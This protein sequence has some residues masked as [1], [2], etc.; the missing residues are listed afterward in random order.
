MNIRHSDRAK[1]NPV[2]RPHRLMLA[3]ALAMA[4]VPAAGAAPAPVND[5]GTITPAHWPRATWPLADDP[6]M[7]RR[8]DALIA[9]MTLEE[10]VGQIVQGDIASIT[11]DDVRRYRL[12][13]ILAGG[14]SDPGGRY[15]A[16]PAEWLAL[17]DAFWEAS[18]DTRNGGKAIPIVWGIDAMHGQSNVVGATLFPHNIGLGAARNPELLREIARITAAETRVTGME[19][20]FAPTVAVPQD[21]R[22]GRT[23]E[24]YSEDPALVASYAGAFVEGLQGKAGAADFLDDHHVMTTVK[25]FLGDGGT[26]NGKDQGNT[27]VSE[28]ELRDIHAAGYLPA[29]NA[30]AQ[31][32]MASFNSFH[33]EKMHGHK[34]LLTDVLKGRMGFG[35]FVVGDWNGHGQIKGCSNTDCAKTYVAGL[36]MAMAPDSWKGM[37]ESTLAHVKDGSLPEARLDDAVRRI[38]RAKMRMGLF[39]KPKPSERALGGRFELLG[40]PAHRQVARQAVRE[41]L[42]LLKNQNQLLPLP[43]KQRVLVAGDAAN[44]MSR[45]AGGWTLSWQGDGTRREDFP[46]AET[47][48]EGLEAQVRSGGGQAELAVDGRYRSRPDVAIVVFGEDPYAEFQGDLPNLMFKNGKS[49]DLE[50]MRRLKADGIPVVGVF[51]SGRPLW[52]NREINAADAFVAAWLPGSEGGGVADVLLRGADGRV[53]HDFRGKLSY[54]WPRRAN[55][56]QN[57]VGQKDYDPQFA[58]GYG[59]TYADKGNLPALSEDPGIDPDAAGS[60]TLFDRGVAG[61]GLMLRLTAANGESTDV[62]HPNATTADQSL[63]MVAINTDVQEGARRFSFRAPATVALQA[64]TPLDWS[65]ETNGEL[66][67]V[68]TM[69]VDQLPAEAAVTLGTACGAACAAEVALGPAL[70]VAPRNEWVRLGVPLKCLAKAGADMSRLNVPFALRAGKGTTLAITSVVLG[71]E[72]DRKVECASQ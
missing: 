35:G 20:T 4:L 10:K 59:L 34:P 54:S 9:S 11:P 53:Q 40:A 38:L 72:F 6:A 57:N 62:V 63:A 55:Q 51:L 45:Q 23:Y 56:Y 46:N 60:G 44:D 67:V 36:D 3:A 18:M 39:D 7:E 31:S 15:N 65:R 1:R 28:A 14:A 33:G 24:G 70:S 69:R 43:P 64:N 41:S 30:G 27:T 37:Y 48:W 25:H 22:W 68:A 26:G 2:F 61:T 42:V 5:A 17:A 19:W 8:I 47:I 49:G 32:V 52:L 12:G 50:L 58:F 13:S 71:T 16:K 66:S 29:I 21:D